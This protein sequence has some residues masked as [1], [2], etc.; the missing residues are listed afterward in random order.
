MK[1]LKIPSASL[2]LSALLLAGCSGP[3]VV[4]LKDGRQLQTNDAPEYDEAGF[5]TFE[6]YG[7]R[8]KVREDDID[9]IH[10]L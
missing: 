6:R 1:T 5:Y 2:L 10:D 7:R 8:M 9:N 3:A 4:I